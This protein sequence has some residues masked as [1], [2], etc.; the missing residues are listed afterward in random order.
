MFGPGGKT[1]VYL[2]YGM[3]HCLNIVCGDD[4]HPS[5]VLVRA[6]ELPLNGVSASGPGR[7]C[8]AFEIDRGDDGV[9]LSGSSI[10]LEAAAPVLDRRVRR[11]RR[12]GVD[13]AGAWARRKLRWVIGDHPE[14][15][16]PR[17]LI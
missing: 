13:Y 8:K 12:I 3:H 7:L 10:W 15:S 1:Y 17:N 11:T 4:G 16:G 5:A 2:I 9:S 14:R 6:A